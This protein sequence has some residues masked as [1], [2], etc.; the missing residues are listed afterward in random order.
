MQKEFLELQLEQTV[1]N[2]IAYL[3]S[4]RNEEQRLQLMRF[5]KT[6]KGDY[7]EG[8]EFLG[9]KVPQT[10]EVVNLSRFASKSDNAQLVKGLGYDGQVMQLG[11]VAYQLPAIASDSIDVLFYTVPF[12]PLHVGVSNRIAVSVDGGEPQVFE[13][14]FKE[15]DLTW[16]NQVLRNGAPCRLLFAIDKTKSSHTVTFH[17]LDNGQ[18]LQKVII[19][20]GGLQQSYLGPNQ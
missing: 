17:A 6:G 3:E 16:K 8:D 20:W 5:F 19:S 15:Y 2:I 14:K 7:G 1:Q 9:L 12:W 13:N 10:R 4:L 11:H 18:M